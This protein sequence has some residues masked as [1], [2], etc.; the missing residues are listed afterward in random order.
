MDGRGRDKLAGDCFFDKPGLATGGTCQ[1]ADNGDLS[2][3][4]TR[5]MN[6][7]KYH[8]FFDKLEKVRLASSRQF[9]GV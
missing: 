4:S 8:I 1:H 6:M 7:S 9:D 2:S 3:L 5:R